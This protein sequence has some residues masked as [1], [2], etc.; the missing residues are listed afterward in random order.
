MFLT[1]NKIP[2]HIRDLPSGVLNSSFG[3]MIRPITDSVSVRPSKAHQYP[4][5]HHHQHQEHQ[6]QYLSQ[7]IVPLE[8]LGKG[9]HLMAGSLWTCCIILLN[10]FQTSSYAS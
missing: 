1:G 2:Q 8:R 5:H 10:S 4:L 7:E 9:N 6:N 3:Q